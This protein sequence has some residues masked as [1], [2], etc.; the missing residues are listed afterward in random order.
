MVNGGVAR[1]VYMS[2]V[3]YMYYM[4]KNR[5]ENTTLVLICH[6]AMHSILVSILGG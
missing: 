3:I 4:K 5:G 1:V 6:V 2:D